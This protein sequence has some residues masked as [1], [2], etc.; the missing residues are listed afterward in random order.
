MLSRT[1]LKSRILPFLFLV[2]LWPFFVHAET[3]PA[4]KVKAASALME[5]LKEARGILPGE[6]PYFFLEK[7]LPSANFSVA[8]AYPSYGEIYLE[9]SAYDLC[10]REFGPD[11]LN[12]LSVI[13]AHELV[14]YMRKHGV[15]NHFA[16]QFDAKYTQDSAIVE[17]LSAGLPE[18][19]V[20]SSGF[21]SRV[22]SLLANF[23]SRKKE[24]EADLEGGFLSYLAGYP[25]GD[26]GPRLMDKIYSFYRIPAVIPTYP[27][28]EERRNIS[29]NTAERLKELQYWF[30][31]ANLMI[32]AGQYEMALS[33]YHRLVGEFQ[34][35]EM[36][37]NMGVI[38]MLAADQLF[39]QGERP[40][41]VLPYSLDLNSRLARNSR[42]G[43]GDEDR[44][45]KEKRDSLLDM[46][47]SYF[48]KASDLD[49]DYPLALLNMGVT[50]WMRA[51]SWKLDHK[52]SEEYL[53]KAK[54]LALQTERIVRPIMTWN[55][56]DR[57]VRSAKILQAMISFSSRDTSS[58]IQ[59]L[60][61][62]IADAP[63][64]SRITANLNTILHPDLALAKK[65][66]QC[67]TGGEILFRPDN[68]VSLSVKNI[69]QYF[70]S[71][72]GKIPN[73]NIEPGE[74]PKEYK[75]LQFGF[76]EDALG[77][78]VYSSTWT[79][80][81]D[82]I[83]QINYMWAPRGFKEPLPCN[84]PLEDLD[85]DG[86]FQQYGDP[87]TTIPF[88]RGELHYFSK[89][90]KVVNNQIGKQI[91]SEWYGL[92]I[93]I[94]NEVPVQWGLVLNYIPI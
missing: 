68:V 46:A 92:I 52:L 40:G 29:I 16:W 53:A 44:I 18:S 6:K 86:V 61:G 74:R 24:A 39:Q 63:N 49:G 26:I 64:D 19:D 47:V 41:F 12:A 32:V 23:E 90:N 34:G 45:R 42:G 17:A 1:T 9:E 69:K 83:G 57:T 5:A 8:M 82:R 62:L 21:L 30:E 73:H 89:G 10:V 58:A 80:W 7:T 65:S 35:R 37:N 79:D 33:N 20:E 55:G 76:Q 50:E 81:S 4:Y 84:N 94:E 36:Y 51:C 88:A 31:A 67:P 25:I 66:P 48:Q 13:L 15:K 87:V 11:S 27:S 14:H 85:L 3:V 28:L 71:I 43:D 38:C 70:N 54:G 91:G 56:R 75:D 60:S 59:L 78:A 2:F 72:V 77:V 93:M 22:E